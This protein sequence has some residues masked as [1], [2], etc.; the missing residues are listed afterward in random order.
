[1]CCEPTYKELKQGLKNSYYGGK[2]SC[3]P[4]YKELKQ[5]ELK[6]GASLENKLRAYL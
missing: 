4:T 3:E 6:R 1:M 5:T 2:F